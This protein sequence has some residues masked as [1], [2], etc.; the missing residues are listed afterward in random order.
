MRLQARLRQLKSLAGPFAPFDTASAPGDPGALFL[1][2]LEDAIAAGIREPHAMTL[3]T[4][5][6]DGRPDARVLILKNIDANG[7]HFA[8]TKAGPKGRQLARQPHAALTFYWQPLG[9]Q[10]RLRGPVAELGREVC[11]ADFRAR[12][13]AARAGALAERQ[14]DVIARDGEVEAALAEQTLRLERDP[15]LVS[16]AWTVYALDPTE[17]EFWQASTDRQHMRL[18]YRKTSAGGWSR[19]RLWP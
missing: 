6:D 2:W 5:D 7:W 11:E 12:P 18:R 17:I 14:S 15:S 4:V 3:S 19:D 13:P 9:R 1:T 8:S 16:P 10:V